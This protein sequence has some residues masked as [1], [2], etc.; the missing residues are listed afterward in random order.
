MSPTWLHLQSV[1]TLHSY[2]LFLNFHE[3]KFSAHPN[4]VNPQL[5]IQILV[6]IRFWI[7]WS[8]TNNNSYYLCTQV[9][10]SLDDHQN[11]TPKYLLAMARLKKKKG[12][13]MYIH[14]N[15]RLFLEK[16]LKTL[17]FSHFP[18]KRLKLSFWVG[19]CQ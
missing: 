14:L 7:I 13:R 4:L 2:D 1:K 8:S 17:F 6:H 18:S 12:K 9:M 16:L 3:P 15:I 19:P 10:K 11:Q 5:I